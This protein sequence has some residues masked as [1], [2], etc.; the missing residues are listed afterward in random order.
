M[1]FSEAKVAATAPLPVTKPAAGGAVGTGHVGGIFTASHSDETYVAVYRKR[2]EACLGGPF[3]LL[4]A[5]G[6]YVA[7]LRRAS[8][9][10]LSEALHVTVC[11]EEPDEISGLGGVLP[12]E[13]PGFR[14]VLIAA[15]TIAVRPADV[16]AVRDW[17]CSWY[18]SQKTGG[19]SVLSQVCWTD[20]TRILRDDFTWFAGALSWFRKRGLPYRRAYL[21]WGPPGCG[22][23]TTIRAATKYFGRPAD[24]FDFTRIGTTDSSF[25]DWMR[26]TDRPYIV[27]ADGTI[28]PRLIVFEDL[29]R[30][31]P[32]NR[33]PQARCGVSLSAILNGLD[34]VDEL[35]GTIVFATANHPEDL[36]QTVL[37]R[38]GR[39]DRRVHYA[40]PTVEQAKNYLAKIFCLDRERVADTTLAHVAGRLA[41]R[42]FA[43]YREVFVSSAVAA[44]PHPVDDAA[45]LR[46]LD[47]TLASLSGGGNGSRRLGITS[48]ER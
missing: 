17:I 3:V 46:A 29:D 16:P 48:C 1:H 34:G 41:G 44:A 22:K 36:D 5:S 45:V 32:R 9:L 43:A 4:D 13:G 25:L 2:I 20:S 21:L 12:Y 23:T 42:S 14:F 28:R 30:F 33:E 31:F 47:E 10:R 19:E 38:S 6:I 18:R 40:P 27:P 11:P 35:D 26:A 37:T 15:I 8:S 7:A 39:F 24:T